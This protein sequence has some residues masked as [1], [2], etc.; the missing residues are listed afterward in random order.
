MQHKYT[1]IT[2]TS[3]SDTVHSVL[4]C[5]KLFLLWLRLPPI[6]CR[7]VVKNSTSLGVLSV[8]LS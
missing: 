4:Q 1:E 3:M 2:N 5:P 8:V 7:L 6:H